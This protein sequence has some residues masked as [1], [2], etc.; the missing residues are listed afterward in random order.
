MFHW[1]RWHALEYPEEVLDMVGGIRLS[2]KVQCDPALF[3][4]ESQ[5]WMDLPSQDA[6]P[7]LQAEFNV[8][9]ELAS[10]VPRYDRQC[11]A[12]DVQDS[13]T[14][15]TNKQGHILVPE[16]IARP[17]RASQRCFNCGSYGHGLKECWR[18]R[19]NE[20]IDQAKAGTGIKPAHSAAKRY[21]LS[22]PDASAASD[23]EFE[24][25]Q[26]GKLS[27]ELREALGVGL[28][29]PPP[30]IGRMRQ[31]GYPPGYM[32]QQPAEQEAAGQ[33]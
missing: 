16:S 27:T 17:P 20:A 10:D 1:A 15:K 6:K 19:D 30:W 25:L 2:G 4:G 29:D 12:L 11:N 8:Q 14:A 26:P 21:F 18:Q 23:A 31:L 32:R 5:A 22:A 9:Y 24:G 28:L 33:C 13:S 7:D 3:S